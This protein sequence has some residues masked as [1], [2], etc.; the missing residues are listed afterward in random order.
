MLRTICLIGTV[1]PAYS[2]APPPDVALAA[3]MGYTS[4]HHPL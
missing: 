1:V 3:G 4:I 2:A